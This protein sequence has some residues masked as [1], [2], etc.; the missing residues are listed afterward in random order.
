MAPQLL[1]CM[2]AYVGQLPCS[3]TLLPRPDSLSGAP[4]HAL[5]GAI[6]R[7]TQVLFPVPR[8]GGFSLVGW[9]RAHGRLGTCGCLSEF[10][11]LVCSCVLLCHQHLH[12]VTCRSNSV[13]KLSL[14]LVGNIVYF[15]HFLSFQAL[16]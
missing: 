14:G 6:Q 4:S 7:V 10:L 1:I 9:L 15:L 8:A 13:L 2:S 3:S 11:L 16:G 12:R 5:A